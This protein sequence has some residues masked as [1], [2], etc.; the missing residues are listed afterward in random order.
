MEEININKKPSKGQQLT[1]PRFK[2]QQEVCL[3]ELNNCG[4]RSFNG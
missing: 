3:V 2:E 1:F 4:V